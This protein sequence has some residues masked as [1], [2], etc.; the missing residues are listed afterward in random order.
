MTTSE[1]LDA[2]TRPAGVIAIVGAGFSGTMVACH[3]LRKATQPLRI[4]LLDRSE[5]FGV[6]LA[7]GSR[8]PGHLLNVSAGAMSAWPHDP[9]H[10]LRWL[11]LNREALAPLL[12]DGC[13]A[14]SFLP[15]QVFGLYLQS[16]LQLAEST[17]RH[18]LERRRDE[19]IDLLPLEEEADRR[20]GFLL[21]CSSGASI[22]AEQVVLAWGNSGALAATPE[23]SLQRLG[24]AA[25]ATADLDPEATVMI[26]GTGLTM[27]DVVVSL[28]RQGHRG[29]VV[30]LSRRGLRP[31]AHHSVTPIGA[32]LAPD[33]APASVLALWRLIRRHVTQAE[34]QGQDWRAVI[35]G[36]RPVTQQLWQ[37]LNQPERRRFLRH[38]AVFW[39]VHRHRIAPQLDALLQQE[40]DSGRLRLLAGRLEQ[41]LERDGKLDIRIRRRGSHRTEQIRVDRLI[42]CTGIPLDYTSTDQACLKQLR[43]RGLLQADALGLGLTTSPVGALLKPD[44]QPSVGL[45][46]LGS[47]RKGQLWESIAVP[48]LRQQAEAL[49]GELLRNLSR[50]IQA[51]A[52]APDPTL[53]ASTAGSVTSSKAPFLWRQ[54]FDPGSSSYTYLIADPTS[55]AALLVDPVLEQLDRDLAL[56]E[57]LDLQLRYCLETHLH[58]DH[59]TAAGQLRRRTGCT[60]IVPNATGIRQ[61][62]RI[63]RDGDELRLDSISLRA[64]A[65]PG[66]TPE[67]LCYLVQETHLLSGDALLI[68]GCGRTD[69]QNG[70]AGQLYDSL[71]RLLALPDQTLVFPAHDEKGRTCS[72]IGEERRHNP[73]VAGRDRGSFIALM[74]SL[75]LARPKR[76]EQAIP[77]NLHL[78][79]TSPADQH[80]GE[81]AQQ[82]ET[83]QQMHAREQANLEIFNDYIAM[84]I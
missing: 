47:A 5:R 57:E 21:Q 19:L 64:L 54:L 22:Q 25:D 23:G 61:A 80:T 10:L 84:Y 69:F 56:I 2:G 13:D 40:L 15:R 75:K 34:Q 11:E 48:E 79:D 31:N 35:D 26:L 63:L 4:V 60:L 77:A 83:E 68:R 49:A 71:Q 82:V 33:S 8:D 3:L 55:R 52:P 27:V 28:R 76:M 50:P 42:L 1:P 74:D 67:H 12:P 7:Y 43:Q 65:T 30:A 24:W 6:G 46:T 53:S 59:I 18:S 45:F 78:G 14:S 16:I 58:A 44:G 37:R 41:Q 73:R 39:D 66:H 32:W 29:Q 38:A 20:G 70:D 62:D 81:L 17:S 72:S 51:L 9:G 36:L